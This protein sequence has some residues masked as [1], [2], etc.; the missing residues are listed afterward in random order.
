MNGAESCRPA[1]PVSSAI[2]LK[3]LLL[4]AYDQGRL[5]VVIPGVCKVF[6]PAM[7]SWVKPQNPWVLGIMR[8][9]YQLYL[10]AKFEDIHPSAL[11]FH[12]KKTVATDSEDDN[13][14]ALA[15]FHHDFSISNITVL[16]RIVASVREGSKTVS[17]RAAAIST[18]T[19][20]VPVNQDFASDL[21]DQVSS[22]Q[23]I[24]C[25]STC[26]PVSHKSPLL[27]L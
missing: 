21:S 5:L 1:W 27:I 26:L 20:R 2:S 9:L 25:P 16:L 11:L 15:L 22:E 23:S 4:D 10:I 8:I 6:E 24:K 3:D 12:S 19:T 7:R 14:A 18:L 13:L 17:K